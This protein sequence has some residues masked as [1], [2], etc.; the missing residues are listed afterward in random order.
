MF[1]CDQGF[2]VGGSG[3]LLKISLG[4]TPSLVTCCTAR[5]L[6]SEVLLSCGHVPTASGRRAL[7]WCQTLQPTTLPALLPP[8]AAQ[9]SCM[10]MQLPEY[11]V[12][13]PQCLPQIPNTLLCMCGCQ[14]AAL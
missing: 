8:F 12:A 6:A 11:D 3:H 7:S 10:L 13:L 5:G 14:R 1:G 4:C 2:H 9:L